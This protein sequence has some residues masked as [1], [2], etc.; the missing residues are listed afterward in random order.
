MGAFDLELSHVRREDGVL[1]V[2]VD[3]DIDVYTHPKLRDYLKG[4][5]VECDEPPVHVGID[6]S[7]C[8]YLDS[9]GLGVLVGLLNH[10]RKRELDWGLFVVAPDERT[11]KIFKITGMTNVLPVVDSVEDFH[12]MWAEL[13]AGEPGG[14]GGEEACA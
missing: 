9:C 11:A 3:G 6:L 13:P 10:R 2:L 1:V 8:V 4:L 5:V 7:D 14:A 12:R